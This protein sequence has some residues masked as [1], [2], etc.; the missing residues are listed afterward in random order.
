MHTKAKV[1]FGFWKAQDL[2][3]FENLL[4]LYPKTIFICVYI[5]TMSVENERGA[6]NL[7]K[8]G[9]DLRSLIRRGKVIFFCLL[10]VADLQNG[11]EK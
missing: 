4:G 8:N 11:N 6:D 3:G 2:T 1:V 10:K 5:S 9:Q 7:S